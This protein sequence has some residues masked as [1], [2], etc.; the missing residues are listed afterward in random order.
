MIRNPDLS[1]DELDAET[2]A[3][4]PIREAMSLIA[5]DPSAA[6]A[7]YGDTS[8]LVSAP[9][10]SDAASGGSISDA[11]RTLHVSQSETSTAG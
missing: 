2:A 11:D 10:W 6:I 3:E 9:D 1:S 7:R 4:L 8:G 5:T